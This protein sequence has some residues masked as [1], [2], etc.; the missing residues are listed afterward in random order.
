M[1]RNAIRSSNTAIPI[2]SWKCS[3]IDFNKIVRSQVVP[4][5]RMFLILVASSFLEIT[6]PLYTQHLVAYNNNCQEIV[7]W[8]DG[9]WLPEEVEHGRAMKAYVNAVWPEFDWESSYRRFHH[10]FEPYCGAERYQPSRA[11]EML[12]RCITETGAT[13]F[14]KALRDHTRELVLRDILDQMQRD[15]V[16]H[17][18][19]FLRYFRHYNEQEKNNKWRIFVT[20]L[21]RSSRVHSEDVFIACKHAYEG[22]QNGSVFTRSFYRRAI[23]DIKKMAYTDYPYELAVKMLVQPLGFSQNIRKISIGVL[24]RALR[25]SL[26]IGF[27]G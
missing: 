1:T 25:S 19:H 10:E 4:D 14:Y 7:D 17:Y 12:A 24:S 23:S 15:E 5:R 22:C 27:L 3:D 2:T 16:R 18:K 11:L 8:L 26:S 6:A 21:R 20:V 13:T 9:V